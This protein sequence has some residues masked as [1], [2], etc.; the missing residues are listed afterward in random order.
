MEPEIVRICL[1]ETASYPAPRRFARQVY[2]EHPEGRLDG[3][4]AGFPGADVTWV[5][6]SGEW[7]QL[8]PGGPAEPPALRAV[9][10]LRQRGDT[11]SAL[12]DSDDRAVTF[13]IDAAAPD[14]LDALEAEVRSAIKIDVTPPERVG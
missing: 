5:G 13:F 2:L 12:A 4:Q 9:L 6:E 1:G 11:L 14:D 3:V 10:V 8:R 7:P